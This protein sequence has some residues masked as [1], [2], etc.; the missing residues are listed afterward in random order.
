M[1]PLDHRQ[2][3]ELE[4]LD[5][6]ITNHWSTQGHDTDLNPLPENVPSKASGN[7]N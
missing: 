5:K 2:G 7:F 1:Q 4:R 3:A 6:S